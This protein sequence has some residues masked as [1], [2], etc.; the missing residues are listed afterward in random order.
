MT[1]TPAYYEHLK[2]TDVKSFIT[3]GPGGTKLRPMIMEG[4]EDKAGWLKELA[5]SV[6]IPQ[7]RLA[8]RHFVHTILK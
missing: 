5:Y 8:N 2:I 7:K 1:N 6:M 4:I 3:T